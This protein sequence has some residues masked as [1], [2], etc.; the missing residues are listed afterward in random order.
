MASQDNEEKVRKQFKKA[1]EIFEK[2]K[3]DIPTIKELSI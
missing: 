3:K 1:K 2:L